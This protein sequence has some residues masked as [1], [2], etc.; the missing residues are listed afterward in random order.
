MKNLALLIPTFTI[1]LC[2]VML[3]IYVFV[4]DIPHLLFWGF[5]LL[6]NE[7]VLLSNRRN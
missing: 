6:F 2:L 7:L 3:V 5:L 1:T 4:G